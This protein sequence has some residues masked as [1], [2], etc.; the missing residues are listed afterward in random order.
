MTLT[1]TCQNDESQVA[2]CVCFRVLKPGKDWSEATSVHDLKLHWM[3]MRKYATKTMRIFLDTIT[4]MRMILSMG[5][6]RYPTKVYTLLRLFIFLRDTVGHQGVSRR[7]ISTHRWF[8]Q[9]TPLGIRNTRSLGTNDIPK[10]P[11]LVH[12]LGGLGP[13]PQTTPHLFHRAAEVVLDVSF[14]AQSQSPDIPGTSSRAPFLR[15]TASLQAQRLRT[16]TP[17]PSIYYRR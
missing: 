4:T 3:N 14:N 17:R 9:I 13:M 16:R 7:M 6:L 8:R 2:W 15:H 10:A 12:A 1:Y 5:V 11:S